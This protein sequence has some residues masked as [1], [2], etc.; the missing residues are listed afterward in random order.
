MKIHTIIIGLGLLVLSIGCSSIQTT[1]RPEPNLYNDLMVGVIGE[2]NG[3]I[4]A[5]FEI[6]APPIS[7]S[8]Y[9]VQIS[10]V[11]FDKKA[12][13]FYQK[14]SILDKNARKNFDSLEH[15]PDYY[16]I[17]LTDD[18]S[19]ASAIN[20]HKE[21]YA[22]AKAQSNT[23]VVTR[24]KCIIPSLSLPLS[25]QW[26]LD[27]TNSKHIQFHLYDNGQKTASVA[28][29]E[30]HVFDYEVSQPCWGLDVRN[31]LQII[32]L[33]APSGACRLPLRK[34]SEKLKNATSYDKF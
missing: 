27:T 22:F 33:I 1:F 26:F 9:A 5:R 6:K 8:T 14:Q 15:I 19:Y 13:R 29:S 21:I 4:N 3:L 34:N 12:Y 24:I 30:I 25:G 20:D 18:L 17:E 32:D 10:R 2:E 31:K 23:K 7:G 28:S 16:I 11:P